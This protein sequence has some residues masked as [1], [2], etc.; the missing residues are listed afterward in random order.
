MPEARTCAPYQQLDGRTRLVVPL[1]LGT[2]F[3]AARTLPALGL[4][5][6]PLLL[7]VLLARPPLRP[8][9]RSL[10][11]PLPFLLLLAVLQDRTRNLR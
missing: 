4:L 5:F 9:V 11:V 10:L 1:L 3:L 2:A 6:V 7:V 8:L